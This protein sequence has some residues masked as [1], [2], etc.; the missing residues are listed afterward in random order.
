MTARRRRAEAGC[1]RARL[2]TKALVSVPGAVPAYARQT[3]GN[4]A[5]VGGVLLAELPAERRLLVEHD[6]EVEAERQA[7]SI[8]QDRL[9]AEEEPLPDDHRDDGDVAGI[10][11]VAEP[12]AHDQ[13]LGRRDGRRIAVT[14]ADETDEEIEKDGK[15]EQEQDE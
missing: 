12:A 2:A 9:A 1:S 10:A 3:P 14:P 8:G 15:R 5:A 7:G 11:H 4:A 13:P 6:E